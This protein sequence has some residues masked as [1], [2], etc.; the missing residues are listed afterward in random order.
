M[1]LENVA[2]EDMEVALS[3]TVDV[4]D[5]VYTGDVDLSDP[6]V[7]TTTSTKCKAAGKGISTTTCVLS[8]LLA[9]KPCPHTSATYNFVA[10][11]GAVLPGATKTKAEG[12]LVLRENDEDTVAGGGVGCV[13]TWS[14]K[15][16]P[17]T[18][19][20]CACD[21]SISSAGQTKAKAQ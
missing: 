19:V 11:A 17:F 10:G 3:N 5:L 6:G 7:S 9:G 8:W 1:A 2:N 14:L 4:G 20:P 18:V 12:L 21:I 16:N 15:V 13:G